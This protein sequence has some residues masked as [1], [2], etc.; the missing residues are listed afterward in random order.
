MLGL[1]CLGGVGV[2]VIELYYLLLQLPLCLLFLGS[3]HPLQ[4]RDVHLIFVPLSLL[5]Y[6]QIFQ[7]LFIRNSQ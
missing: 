3:Q 5:L 7:C 1:Q 6:L 4:T 2:T